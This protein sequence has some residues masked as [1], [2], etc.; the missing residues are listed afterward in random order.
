MSV[1]GLAL[2]T[3]FVNDQSKKNNYNNKTYRN[4]G[5]YSVL[6]EQQ[7]VP[8]LVG[9][10]Y[11]KLEKTK[12]NQ[13]TRWVAPVA[14]AYQIKTPE[15]MEWFFPIFKSVKEFQQSTVGKAFLSA[16]KWWKSDAWVKTFEESGC[17]Y[18]T[19]IVP[20]SVRGPQV[21]EGVNEYGEAMRA[22]AKDLSNEPYT[23]QRGYTSD[24][25]DNAIP[26]VTN[27][28]GKL[29][30]SPYPNFILP[31][32]VNKVSSQF[33]RGGRYHNIH[34]ITYRNETKW[35]EAY[36]N[37]MGRKLEK[38]HRTKKATSLKALT[39]KEKPLFPSNYSWNNIV[40]EAIWF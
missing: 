29:W 13:Y 5:L 18:F 39:K 23:N 33:S 16:N 36:A 31:V 19:P 35:L 3:M 9:R 26:A 34:P 20:V 7:L 12:R 32:P 17:D 28:A 8:I 30:E 24:D 6:I 38:P 25:D 15:G 11:V 22:S 10:P 14:C 40:C 4:R 2:D 37:T 27:E 1:C 21:S